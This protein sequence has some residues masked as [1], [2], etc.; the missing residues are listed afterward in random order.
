MSEVGYYSVFCKHDGKEVINAVVGPLVRT[1]NVE[2]DEGGIAVGISCV[3]S[4]YFV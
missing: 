3:D 2:D 1:K 4:P